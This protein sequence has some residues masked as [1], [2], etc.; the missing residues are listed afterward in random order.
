MPIRG[1]LSSTIVTV[2]VTGVP[3]L[4]GHCRAVT[5]CPT[6]PL[7]LLSENPVYH[8][9]RYLENSRMSNNPTQTYCLNILCTTVTWTLPGCLT[10]PIKPTVWIYTWTLWDTSQ[11]SNCP[12]QTYCLSTPSSKWWVWVLARLNSTA[13]CGHSHFAPPKASERGSSP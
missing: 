2:G 6:A 4:F 1:Y 11:I 7:K 8:T 9:C 10:A 13:E 3:Q 5:G 12:T